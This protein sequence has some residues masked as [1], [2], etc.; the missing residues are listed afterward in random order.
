M[1]GQGPCKGPD[2]SR[3]H[4]IRTGRYKAKRKARGL[5]KAYFAHLRL[6]PGPE[7]CGLRQYAA[8]SSTPGN[9]GISI[10]AP[11]LSR[12]KRKVFVSS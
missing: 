8:V 7:G 9:L 12:H 5:R 11:M 4:G 2:W 6:G 10:Q 3:D 1:V